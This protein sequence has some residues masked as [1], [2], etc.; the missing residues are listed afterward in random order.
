MTTETKDLFT[1]VVGV[2]THL[3][4]SLDTHV[5]VCICAHM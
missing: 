1:V 3:E 5:H 4:M 2:S